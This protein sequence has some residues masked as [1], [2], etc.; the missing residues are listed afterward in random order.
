MTYIYT[1][2]INLFFCY[3]FGFATQGELLFTTIKGG[4]PRACAPPKSLK[5]RRGAGAGLGLSP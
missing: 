1:F 4:L 2:F 3:C 5:I